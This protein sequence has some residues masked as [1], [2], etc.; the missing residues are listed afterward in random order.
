[1]IGKAAS[2]FADR[3]IANGYQEFEVVETME[4]AV[5]RGAQLAQEK[6]ANV[7]LL[8]PACASFDQY[9][10]FEH[11]GDHFRE[12]CQPFCQDS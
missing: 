4:K 8:S 6:G 5:P 7:V 3:L 11:R 10:S 12:L 1:L 9:Q 2:T